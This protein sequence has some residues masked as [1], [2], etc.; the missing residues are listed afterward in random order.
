MTTDDIEKLFKKHH[1][2]FLQ[3]DRIQVKLSNRPD[4]HA[5]MLLDKIQPGTQDIVSAAAHDEFYLEGRP[6]AIENEEQVIDL[7][8]CGVRY[9]SHLDC[10]AMFT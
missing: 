9:D 5:F 1:A 7:L 10:L 6:E 3:F 8:R 4:L 2:E